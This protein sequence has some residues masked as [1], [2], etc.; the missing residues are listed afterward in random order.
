MLYNVNMVV[1]S[2]SEVIKL[3]DA[4]SKN[5]DEKM[6]FHDAC[7]GQYFTLEKTNK[8]LQKFI[9]DFMKNSGYKAIFDDDGL[10]FTL[11]K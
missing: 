1:I 9:T 4:V 8:N 2:F 3:K 10:S 5:F 11:S 7:G 6:H